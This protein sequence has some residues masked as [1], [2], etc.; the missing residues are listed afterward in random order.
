M[1][2]SEGYEFLRFDAFLEKL[3]PFVDGVGGDDL[4]FLGGHFFVC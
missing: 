1:R 3:L 2:E 4:S